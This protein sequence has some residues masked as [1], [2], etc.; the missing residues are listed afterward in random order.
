MRETDRQLFEWINGLAGEWRALDNVMKLLVSDFFLPVVIA[1][2]AFALWFWGR[3]LEERTRNQW[4]FLYAVIGAGFANLMVRLINEHFYRARPFMVLDDVNVLF[5]QPTD[6]SFPSNAS[7]Y[8]FAMA[9]GVWL[10]NRRWGALIGV[11]AVLFSFARIYAGMHFPFDVMGGAL[12]GILTT[13]FFARVLNLFRP[14]VDRALGL[15]R[16]F[17][18]A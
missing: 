9:A 14:V 12:L 8:A 6:P 3:A 5:Y 4:G 2:A 11:G 15:V 18:L 13:W 10:T 17:H 7:A 1:L 16:W